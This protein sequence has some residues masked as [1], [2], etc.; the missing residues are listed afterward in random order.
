MKS[1][2]S[3]GRPSTGGIRKE[4][5]TWTRHQIVLTAFKINEPSPVASPAS[6]KEDK[7]KG[8]SIPEKIDLDPTRTIA[9]LHLFEMPD[10]TK[11]S[12][13]RQTTGSIFSSSSKKSRPTTAPGFY[14]L[15]EE[16]AVEV[17]RQLIGCE[18]TAGVWD[19]GAGIGWDEVRGELEFGVRGLGKESEELEKDWKGRNWVI[20]VGFGAK[21]EWFLDM[22]DM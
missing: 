17:D 7:G 15:S 18:T 11:D 10:L 19:A 12:P 9:H 3:F 8:K 2:A 4:K 13:N 16:N 21:G 5:I 20:R 6:A 14:G 22:P 1:L